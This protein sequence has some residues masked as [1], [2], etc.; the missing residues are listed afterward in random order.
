MDFVSLS[1]GSR[2]AVRSPDNSGQESG[3][4]GEVSDA[5]GISVL[6]ASGKVTTDTIV[7]PGAAGGF[8][9]WNKRLTGACVPAG[10]P[11]CRYCLRK[12][13]CR[14]A[15]PRPGPRLDWVTGVLA[16]SAARSPG[17]CG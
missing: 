17:R 2:S 12:S 5:F 14:D 4:R 16:A 8:Q 11:D 1:S 9:T 15:R 10:A 3:E 13:P 6:C 7:I